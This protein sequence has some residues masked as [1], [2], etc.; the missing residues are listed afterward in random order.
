MS[1]VSELFDGPDDELRAFEY[2][3]EHDLGDELSETVICPNC[4]AEVYE[5]SIRCPVCGDYITSDSYV[6]SGRPVWWIIL[7][8]LGIVA[9][10]CVLSLAVW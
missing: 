7:G 3:D 2:P 1:H 5:D 9:V 4:G 8:L 6:W 10:V